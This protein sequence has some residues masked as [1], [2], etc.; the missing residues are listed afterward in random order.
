MGDLEPRLVDPGLAVEEQV[1]IERPRALGGDEGPVPP[2]PRLDHEQEVEEIPGRQAALEGGGPVQETRLVGVAKGRRVDERRDRDHV[3][4]LRRVELGERGPDRRLAVAEVGAEADVCPGHGA[5]LAT[6][7]GVVGRRLLAVLLV[8]LCA[9]GTA[10]AAT[11]RSATEPLEGQEWW[12]ADVGADRADAP[13]PGVPIAIVDSGTDPTHPEFADRPNTTFLNTQSVFGREEYH[14][15][16]VASVAAA[17]ANE[18]G[19]L[20]VYPNAALELYDASSDPRGISDFSAVT[21]IRAAAEHCPAVINL[22]FGSTETDDQ[23]Q[24]AILYAVHNGCLV[25]AAAGNSG[26]FGSPATFPAS[27]PHVFTVGATDEK[28]QIASFS[29]S[30]PAVDVSAPARRASW[31]TSRCS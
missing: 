18:I 31:L 2:E 28:D 20:G 7:P 25:V 19:M 12:L 16:I 24:D 3:E 17:P 11:T 21:G 29:T 1:E 6:L 13:G 30:S 4:A 9:S 27:W 10:A 22:S 14:G 5:T 8:A 23:L 15:T 26:D